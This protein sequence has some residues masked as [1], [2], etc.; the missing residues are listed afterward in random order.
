M[1]GSAPNSPDTGSQISVR[2][3]SNPNWRIDSID[4]VRQLEADRA[5]DEDEDEREGAR[6]QPEPEILFLH[7]SDARLRLRATPAYLPDLPHLPYD[8]LTF[9]SAASSSLTTASGS[10]A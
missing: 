8:V 7:I 1:N 2:Q 10:G 3:K 9:A 6:R 4:C 5:D